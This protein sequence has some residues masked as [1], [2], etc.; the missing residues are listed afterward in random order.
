M[1]MVLKRITSCVLRLL[2]QYI[3]LFL[4]PIC[5]LAQ[6]LPTVKLETVEVVEQRL[7]PFAIGAKTTT[8]DSTLLSLEALPNLA[9]IINYYTPIAVKSYGNGMLSTIS[10]RGTGPSH[11]AVLWHGVNISYPMLGQSDLSMLSLALSNEVSI[12]HG[13]GS[14]LYGSGALGGTVSLSNAN[15]IIGTNLLLT[16]WAGSFGTYKNHVQAS[17]ANAKYF[18]KIA[19]LWDQSNNNFEFNN[20]TRPGV[21][22]EVQEGADY[23]IFG[24][25]VESGFL[26]GKN[27]ELSISG[28]YFNADRNLQPS[29]NANYLQ[30]NQTDENIRIRA[31][32]QTNGTTINW[33]INYAYLHDVIGFNGAKTFA[34]QQVIRAELEKKLYSWLNINV[35]A[36]YNFIKI[37]SPFYTEENTKESRSNVWASLLLNPTERLFISLNL[38]Q[39]FNPQYKIPFTPTLGSEFILIKKSEHQLRINTLLAKG[40]RVPTLNERYWQPGGNLN[41]IPEDSYSAELGFSGKS[42]NHLVYSYELTG[43]RMWVENWILWRPQGSFWSPENVKHVDVYGIEA[44]GSLEHGLFSGKIKWSGNYAFT[45]SINRTGLDQFDRSVDKQLAYVPIHRAT[46][47]STSE[48]NSWSLMVNVSYTGQRFVT[49]DNEESLPNYILLNLRLSK[50]FRASKFLF[51]THANINNLLNTQYQSV[52]NKAMPGINLL[53]GLTI[54]YY[55]P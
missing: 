48:W 41:L 55:K 20:I 6:E 3:L 5:A 39:S 9:D 49:A 24:T 32:Y 15:P 14:A 2:W 30:D 25:S 38:R 19:T 46:V 28:Q 50:S 7:S 35:A 54:S 13:T 31:R 47:T 16:Q 11:T 10:F 40:Y 22:T 18:I 42:T 26:I 51:N 12:Q 33:N 36:D 52:E 21:P 1:I 29:M 4:G 45:K 27:G 43:Y 8:L 53:F 34:D 44:S 37:E 23:N 17:Y